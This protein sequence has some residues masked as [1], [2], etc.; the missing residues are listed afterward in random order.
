[1][2]DGARAAS[3]RRLIGLTL[4]VLIVAGAMLAGLYAYRLQFVQPRTDDAAVRANVVGIAPQVSG[5]IVDLRVVD[6]QHVNAGDLLFAVDC[7]PYEAR[8]A[9]TRADLALALKEVDAQRKSIASAASEIGR[10]EASLAS[11]TAQIARAEEE[12]AA[13]EAAVARLQAEADYADDYLGRI[14]PLLKR[15]FVTADR[16]ADARNK[17]DASAAAVQEA[18]RRARAAAAG[19]EH[20]MATRRDA[21]LAVDQSHHER[22]RAEDLL[23]QVGDF[24]ARVEA[25]KATMRTAELDVGYCQVRAP[26]DAYVTNLNIAVGEYARLGQQVFALVDNRA[27]YVLANFSETYMPSIKPGMEADVY[28]V[29]APGRPFRGVVQGVGWANRPADGETVGVLPDVRRTLNWVRLANRFQVRVRLEERDPEHP[30]RMGTTAVV[31]I[32]GFPSSA[33]AA[34]EPR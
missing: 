3:A 33:S 14:E 34:A 19:V 16:V 23:A 24:N 31:T 7:R 13:A 12:R 6:N 4:R 29:S 30:F 32:R 17:R 21:A 27:W 2:D 20:T 18:R 22:S 28:L 26:F 10:R 15:Q 8:L 25:A 5:P 9:R 1:M 11:A